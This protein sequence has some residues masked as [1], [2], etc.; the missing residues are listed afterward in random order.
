VKYLDEFRDPDLAR[1]LAEQLRAARVGPA[2]LMEVCGTHTMAIARFGL[3]SALPDGVRLVSGPGCPVC[4]TSQGEID[5]FL[6]LGRRPE[7]ILATFGDMLRV[8]GR[9]SSLEKERARGAEVRVLYSP[10]DA[11]RLAAANPQ[12][13]VVF[14]GVGFETTAP[15]VAL[16]VKEA[17]AQ[18]R[19]NFF[20]LCAHK[21]IPPALRALSGDKLRVGGFLCPGHVSTIIGSQAYDFLAIEHSI[22]CVIAGFEPLDVLQALVMLLGQLERGEARVEVQYRRAVSSRG[23]TKAQA[24]LAEVFEVSDAPWRGLG[25]IPA[26]G[27]S[28]RGPYADFDAA[29]H[30]DLS[31]E[32][33]PEPPGCQCGRVLRGAL[34]PEE[35]GLFGRDCTPEH[36]VG[37]CM[38]SSEGA[39]AASY[40]Y[41]EAERG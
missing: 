18:G 17:R 25:L 11:V 8:P 26:S 2:R 6:E 24:L 7:V 13:K 32:D 36:P 23:N 33:A 21:L 35:C 28:L 29:R 34:E 19:R 14:F 27:L 3:R 20:L 1:R 5:R 39:C 4:V 41:P 9:G 12:R 15:G 38:V 31:L 37:P 22:A 10:L 16:A 30:F 40:K